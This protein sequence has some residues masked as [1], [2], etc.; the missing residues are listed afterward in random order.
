LIG[1]LIAAAEHLPKRTSGDERNLLRYYADTE[2]V[3]HGP[4]RGAV[5]QHLLNSGFIE[6]RTVDTRRALVA[7]TSPGR[8]ALRARS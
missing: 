8:R 1:L 2:R 5:H 7:V 3:I 6:E 4:V